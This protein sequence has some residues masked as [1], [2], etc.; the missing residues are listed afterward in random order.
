MR[1]LLRLLLITFGITSLLVLAACSQDDEVK[2]LNYQVDDFTFTNQE[3]QSFGLADLQGKVWVADFVFV[4]CVTV[5]PPMTSNLAMLQNELKKANVEAEIVSFSV[6]PERDTVEVLKQYGT[7]YNVDFSNW[8]FLTGFTQD[9]ISEFA[10]NSFKTVVVQDRKSD[11]VVHGTSFYIVDQSGLVFQRYDGVY[12]TPFEQMVED[13]KYLNGDRSKRVKVDTSTGG[14][15]DN[16]AIS[17]DQ[18]NVEAIYRQSCLSCHGTDLKGGMGPNLQKIGGKLSEEQIKGIIEK[19]Q[20]RMPG[21]A[22]RLKDEQI[23]EL[24]TWLASKK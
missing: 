11:Q 3:G 10:K 13:I 22:S 2:G 19:G 5:C 6:D 12:D 15:A 24:T 8:N 16:G 4:N 1:S 21:F 9:E 7:D 18:A 20:G 17:S 23:Q 14:Q